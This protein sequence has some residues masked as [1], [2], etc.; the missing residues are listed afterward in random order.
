MLD[1]EIIVKFN[2]NPE[3]VSLA[4]NI[5]SCFVLK[6]NPNISE[7]SDIKT[8][9]SE[10]VTNACVHGYKNKNGIITLN[11]KCVDNVIHISIMDEGSGIDDI[12]KAS[13][14]FFTTEPENE[15]TG[16]GI[17]IMQTFMDEFSIDSKLGSGTIV[18]MSKKICG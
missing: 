18:N 16:M 13:Q 15:H 10:A 2:N 9:V 6:L 7:L 3:N 1:K 5:I 17:T 14:P 4:R 11:A 8:A 12:Y